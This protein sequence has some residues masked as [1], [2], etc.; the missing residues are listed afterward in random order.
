LDPV[1]DRNLFSTQVQFAVN[2]A[3]E[4]PFGKKLFTSNSEVL[5][6]EH[7]A[8]FPLYNPSAT[9]TITLLSMTGT[10]QC[11]GERIVISN[12]PGREGIQVNRN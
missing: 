4:T 8:I 9:Y 7:H 6:H 12:L 3:Y 1:I 2:T 11:L 5:T 10:R